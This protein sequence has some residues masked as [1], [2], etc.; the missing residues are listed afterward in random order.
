MASEFIGSIKLSTNYLL[1]VLITSLTEI[2][3][4]AC[5]D[6]DITVYAFSEEEDTCTD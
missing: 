3:T 5:C 1:E 6:S 2:Y 4:P